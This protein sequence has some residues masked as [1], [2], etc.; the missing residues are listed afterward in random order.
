[1]NFLFLCPGRALCQV[2]ELGKFV[3]SVWLESESRIYRL[4]KLWLLHWVCLR[5][6][7]I[8]CYSSWKQEL[9]IRQSKFKANNF[10]SQ[11]FVGLPKKFQVQT[12]CQW[13]KAHLGGV[14][15][16]EKQ[17]GYN[18]SGWLD[19]KGNSNG[20]CPALPESVLASPSGCLY[21]AGHPKDYWDSF[22]V[23]KHLAF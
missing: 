4:S 7:D 1:M 6:N 20:S 14:L 11:S 21:Y 17:E 5:S 18:H 3:P 9:V 2:L 15:F 8:I 23:F 22:F 19:Q 12:L 10:G 13:L 16:C